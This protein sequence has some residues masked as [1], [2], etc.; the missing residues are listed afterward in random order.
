[1]EAARTHHLAT[2]GANLKRDLIRDVAR[3]G[4]SALPSPL[5][6]RLKLNTRSFLSAAQVSE[7][8]KDIQESHCGML[9]ETMARSMVPA[10]QTRDAIMASTLS[11]TSP[12]QSTLGFMG[13]EHARQDRGVPHYLRQYRPQS[14]IVSIHLVEVESSRTDPQGY[15]NYSP[16]SHPTFF[17]FTSEAERSDPC[18]V[19]RKHAAPKARSSP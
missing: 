15:R 4:F 11:E 2:L 14:R 12:S 19:F 7:L 13:N 3:R 6:E 18:E 1:L 9:D 8:T 16:T 5:L 17:W 10:Q